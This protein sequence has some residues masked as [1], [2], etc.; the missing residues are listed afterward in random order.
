MVHCFGTDARADAR[1]LVLLDPQVCPV[2]LQRQLFLSGITPEGLMGADAPNDLPAHY[3]DPIRQAVAAASPRTL[4]NGVDPSQPI[5]LITI[6]DPVYPPLLQLCDDAPPALFTVGDITALAR[7]GVAIV[8]AR[9]A[10]PMGLEA[11]R[12]FAQT[13]AGAGLVVASGLALGID[14]AAHTGAL[15]ADGSSVAVMPTGIDAVYPRRHGVLARQLAQRGVVLSEFPPNTAPRRGNF[16]RRNRTLSG[17]TLGTLVVEAGRP[18]GSLITANAATEQGREVLALPW[19]IRHPGGAGCLHLLSRG[20]TLACSPLDVVNQVM[21]AMAAQLTGINVPAETTPKL[22]PVARKVLE[23]LGDECLS[24]DRLAARAG[25]DVVE[26]QQ[27]LSLLEI[28]SRVEK[29]QG[30]WVRAGV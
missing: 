19:S 9:R 22:P 14:G 1:W 18:S 20:A 8:G 6:G 3:L 21:P 30:G 16:P 10:S 24:L 2:P 27:Q 4:D 23:S 17:M 28:D 11:A 15:D 25:L 12:E 26:C 7:P 29:A 13:L 5:R